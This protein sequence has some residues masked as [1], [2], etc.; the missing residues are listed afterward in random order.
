MKFFE[1]L[2]K[3][4]RRIIFI[5]IGII[6][7]ISF[8]I[9]LS[10][11]MSHTDPVKKIYQY[12]EALPAESCVIVS[13]DFDPGSAPELQPMMK[14]FLRHCFRKKIKVVMIA[15]V[16]QGAGLGEIV[17]KSVAEEFGAKAETD[18]V[19]LGW[20]GGGPVAVILGMADSIT[21]IY[22]K[23]FA[24]KPTK[25]M[26]LFRKVKNYN[27]ISLIATFAASATPDAWVVYA[28]TKYKKKIAAGVT[29]VMAAD[30]YPYLNTGQFIG[31]I[32]GL[33]GAAEYEDMVGKPEDA[34]CRMTPQ[35]FIH[36]TII[37]FIIVGN[38]GYFALRKKKTS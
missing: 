14:A 28:Y 32:N 33:K 38:I 21:D 6:V 30:Y 8:F 5:V 27:D 31:L 9:R 22:P 1:W 24:G 19:N 10:L 11:P 4:D 18:Y 3:I 15:L 23:N 37:F 20:K 25:Y 29:A 12:V 34:T 36:L 35:A 7:I 16:P 13:V 2:L 26:P 17:I